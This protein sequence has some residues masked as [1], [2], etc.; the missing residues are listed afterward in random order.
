MVKKLGESKVVDCPPAALLQASCRPH[1]VQCLVHSEL[2]T[3]G[4][5][6]KDVDSLVIVG[7]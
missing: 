6:H 5:K 2:C 3:K 4:G 7:H 1:S